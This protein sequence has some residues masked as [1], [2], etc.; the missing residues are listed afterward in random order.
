MMATP[1][2]RAAPRSGGFRAAGSQPTA[3]SRAVGGNQA[4][5]GTGHRRGQRTDK[6]AQHPAQPGQLLINLYWSRTRL[7]ALTWSFM[8]PAGIR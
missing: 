5:P 1:S 3:Q 8:L 4:T 7:L 6:F 2:S